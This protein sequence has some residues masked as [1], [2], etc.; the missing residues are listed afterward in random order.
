M[1]DGAKLLETS[2]R[3]SDTK[4]GAFGMTGKSG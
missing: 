1:R 3:I 4:S 2:M